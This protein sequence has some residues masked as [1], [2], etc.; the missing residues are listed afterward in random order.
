MSGSSDMP[1]IEHEI[2]RV[3][4]GMTNAPAPADLRR[5]VLSRLDDGVTDA[6]PTVWRG[7]LVWSGAAVTVVIVAVVSWARLAPPPSSPADVMV[8]RTAAP[9]EPSTPAVDVL[10]AAPVVIEAVLVPDAE[11]LTL[12]ALEPVG[13]LVVTDLPPISVLD[14]PEAVD[15]MTFVLAPLAIEPIIIAPLE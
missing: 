7:R 3:A 4:R 6:R 14:S 2:D 8:E 12:V 5:Q 13:P 11:A 10:T 15:D 1:D 9:A